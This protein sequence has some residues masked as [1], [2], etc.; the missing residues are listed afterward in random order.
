[1][2]ADGD[3]ATQLFGPQ[4]LD[5]RTWQ[6]EGVLANG[7]WTVAADGQSVLQGINKDP[8]FF[9][10]PENFINT[11]IRG[12]F[13]VE[14]PGADVPGDF[15]GFVLGYQSPLRGRNDNSNNFLVTRQFQRK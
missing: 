5:L 12:T 7:Q 3:G 2:L 10:S 8:T 1:M 11:T 4:P 14:D 15:I 13:R 6:Q 9:V